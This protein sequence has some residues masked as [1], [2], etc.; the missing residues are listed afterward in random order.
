M[1]FHVFIVACVYWRCILQSNWHKMF[2]LSGETEKK[3][4]VHLM[5]LGF[6][7]WGGGGCHRVTLNIDIAQ[8]YLKCT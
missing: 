5:A 8:D 4:L 7:V 6:S 1:F 2:D 3:S